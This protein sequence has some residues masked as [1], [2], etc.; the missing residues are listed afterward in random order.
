MENIVLPLPLYESKKIGPISTKDGSQL[1]VVIGLDKKLVEQL[2]RK[3]LDESDVDLQKN[4]SDR[5]RFGEGSY[6]EWYAKDRTPFALVDGEGNLA[7]LAWFGPKPLGRKSLRFLSE[8][9]LKKEGEQKETDWHTIVYRAYDPY[10]GKGLM[11]PFVQKA[12]DIYKTYYPK[13]KLW[14]GV[15]TENPASLALARKLGF[16]VDSQTVDEEAHWCAMIEQ[17]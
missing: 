3:S 14:A 1:V 6:E 2:K 11:V 16:K 8:E 12:I 10:R 9:E 4:T 7:A 17:N 15:S 13:A 5:L